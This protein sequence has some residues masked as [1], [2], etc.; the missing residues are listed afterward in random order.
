MCAVSLS[1][2]CSG[3][4]GFL[5]SQVGRDVL[6]EVLT[7]DLA[8][9]IACCSKGSLDR[10][11]QEGGEPAL[12]EEVAV[13][14]HLPREDRGNEAHGASAEDSK[15]FRVEFRRDRL[16]DRRLIEADQQER[17][18]GHI[19]VHAN[20]DESGGVFFVGPDRTGD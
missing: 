14:R 9:T 11:G 17:F 4:V 19:A 1:S 13:H 3:G 6:T 16:S 7:H 10:H 15:L 20:L 8:R 12:P 2:F 18:R 5:L